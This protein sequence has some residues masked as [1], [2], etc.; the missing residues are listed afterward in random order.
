MWLYTKCLLSKNFQISKLKFQESGSVLKPASSP[1]STCNKQA[2]PFYFS[3]V[4]EVAVCSLLDFS[5]DAK[6][7]QQVSN[8][9]LPL[10]KLAVFLTALGK[11]LPAAK[12]KWCFHSIQHW[13]SCTWSPVWDL[14]CTRWK[15]TCWKRTDIGPWRWCRGWTK[16]PP[17]V[18]ASLTLNF[19]TLTPFHEVAWRVFP[20]ISLVCWHSNIFKSQN[21]N[22]W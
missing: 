19:C 16:W 5:E 1:S 17:E 15:W 4:P 8:V 18:L 20:R 11:I 10:R 13:W 6:I 12:G 21:C 2:L 22:F 3:W 7:L 9:P 14:P